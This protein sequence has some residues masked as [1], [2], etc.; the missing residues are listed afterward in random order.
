MKIYRG[1][2]RCLLKECLKSSQAERFAANTTSDGP[3]LDTQ[4]E[5]HG[6]NAHFSHGSGRP[7][8]WSSTS[9]CGYLCAERDSDEDRQQPPGAVGHGIRYLFGFCRFEPVRGR[10]AGGNRATASQAID[11]AAALVGM[12]VLF[13]WSGLDSV[14]SMFS[15][16]TCCPPTGMRQTDLETS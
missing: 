8:H 15:E 7:I 14:V 16:L 13:H 5:S 6:S 3:N 4:S 10:H 2:T 12:V 9:R 11:L 1:K